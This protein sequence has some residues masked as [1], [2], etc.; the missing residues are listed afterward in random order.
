M[1]IQH[2]F[3]DLRSN[4]PEYTGVGLKNFNFKNWEAVI[5]GPRGTPYEGGLFVLDVKF[6]DNYPSSAP[7]IY[8]VTP[9]YHP[10][11]NDYGQV[12][13]NIIRDGWKS[14][15]T[16]RFIMNAIVGLLKY[17][18]PDSPWPNK[19]SI[20]DEYKNNRNAFNSKARNYTDQHAM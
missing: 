18:N 5:T 16:M 6:P 1:S 4:P 8:M 9:I 15:Y 11:I 19:R 13:I 12:C 2:Q 14:H 20:A 10:N 3:N 17:P 7:Q